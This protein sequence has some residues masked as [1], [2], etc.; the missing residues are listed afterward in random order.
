MIR[1]HRKLANFE[2]ELVRKTRPNYRKNLAIFEA[3]HREYLAVG[4]PKRTDPLEGIEIKIKIA[5][6]I[7]SV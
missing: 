5:K 6:A 7:N 3:M 4:R 2:K 1:D